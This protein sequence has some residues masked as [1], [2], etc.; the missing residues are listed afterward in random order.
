MKLKRFLTTALSAL[1]AL[2][3]CALPVMAEGSV[4]Q[5]TFEPNRESGTLTIEKFEQTS[6]Q[7]QKGENGS[8]LAGVQFT[9]YQLATITQEVNGEE[10]SLKYN[11][12]T[13][14][15]NTLTD[16]DFSDDSTTAPI[17]SKAL[18]EKIAPK[19]NVLTD[20]QKTSL[21]KGQDTTKADGKVSFTLPLGIYMVVE[22]DAPSQILTKTA[23]FIVSIPMMQKDTAGD[24]VWNYEILAQPKNVPTYGGVTLIKYGRTAG[25]TATTGL[26]TLKDV[27]FRLDRQNGATWETVDLNDVTCNDC[28]PVQT[29]TGENIQNK[30]QVK[31][32]TLGAINITNLA[33]GKYRFVELEA[34]S[35]YITNRAK[36]H[37]FEV[38]KN[39]GN[40]L[41]V[42][43]GGGKVNSIDVINEKPDFVK[44]ITKRGDTKPSTNHD[45]DYGI[46]DK[47]PYTL[48]VKVPDTIANLTTFKV[49]D[50]VNPGKLQYNNDFVLT[51]K[52]KSGTYTEL[53]KDCYEITCNNDDTD[54]EGNIHFT[55]DFKP[56]TAG[57]T[58]LTANYADKVITIKYTATLQKGAAI[59]NEGN[60][61]TAKLEYSNKTNIDEDNKPTT[62]DN[63]Y[64]IHD[65]GVVYTFQTGIKKT[66]ES[67]N[68]LKDVTFNLYKE[69]DK[70]DETYTE[71]EG[72]AAAGIM[73]QGIKHP[74]ISDD[75]AKKMNL[76]S[77]KKW[78]LVQ[79]LTSDGE[80]EDTAKGLPN[81]TYKLVETKTKEGYNLL[82][83]L[84]DATLSI[85]YTAHWTKKDTY[86]EE[87]K[88]I[89]RTYSESE[90]AFEDDAAMRVITIV[91]RKGFELPVTGGFGT[92]LFSGIGVLLVLGGVSVLFSLKKKNGRA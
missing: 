59:G 51:Y 17:E 83:D 88:L 81:G 70:A 65:E 76:D 67:G 82:K 90:A 69:C 43:V 89:K 31:T 86:N 20:A 80:G 50:T 44:D 39:E 12:N 26:P 57:K 64:E 5:W 87:G 24:Y 41:E 63:P 92:L 28:T 56:T 29:G 9:V 1:M 33:P 77:T 58:G 2:S 53:P 47:V 78:I 23:N 71:T 30:G 48:T 7:A 75:D 60:V 35:G 19:F 3:V 42:R 73:F 84:V 34:N 61:N 4:K 10:V 49:T 62:P 40:E 16:K 18:Y 14:F 8:P 21:Q 32:G 36:A 55:I 72:G 52:N 91:N 45:A 66:D 68:A 22:T 11:V 46:G 13:E 27:I 74:Y 15:G 25:D 54:T 6:E 79:T 37:E 85:Q 38:V